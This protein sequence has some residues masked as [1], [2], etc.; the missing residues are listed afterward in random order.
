M[1]PTTEAKP[2]QFAL[3]LGED[4]FQM[5]K[6]LA[7]DTHDSAAET[8]RSLIRGSYAKRFKFK[9]PGAEIMPTIRAIIDD[10]SGAV[11]YTAGNISTRTGLPLPRVHDLL[12]T[13]ERKGVIDCI[14]HMKPMQGQKVR[15]HSEN[16]TW[17]LTGPRD[18]AFATLEK[19]GL[20]VDTDLTPKD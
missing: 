13:L 8:V 19:A 9:I 10:I 11:H 17:E 1:A 16:W 14:D 7:E 18:R 4:E 3:T 12:R 15:H 6:D 2:K 5:L 20:D